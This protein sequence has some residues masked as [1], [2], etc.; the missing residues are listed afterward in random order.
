M[1]L[2]T[3]GLLCCLDKADARHTT[4]TALYKEATRKIVHNY[5]LAEFVALALARG[6]ALSMTVAYMRTVTM[7]PSVEVL[8]IDE[9][10]HE[11][12]MQLLQQRPDKVYSLCDAVSFE[13][14]RHRNL[15]TALTTDHHFTQEGFAR[16]LLGS[17]T[18]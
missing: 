1:L 17:Q 8:W 10:T 15:F 3:S 7:A 9:F 4:A 16:L 12:G 6:F 13:I 14:L 5:V 11:L 2:D 18:G